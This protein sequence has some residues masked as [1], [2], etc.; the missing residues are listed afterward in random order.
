M[1]P[2]VGNRWRNNGSVLILGESWYGTDSLEERLNGWF[3]RGPDYLLSRVFNAC[4]SSHT[5]A[6]SPT[7]RKAFWNT[8]AFHNFVCWS[9]GP[10]S[11]C[12]PKVA[13]YRRA[14]QHLVSVLR[15]LRPACVWLLGV[16]Q[17]EYSEPVVESQ[18]IVVE[19][20]GILAL[21]SATPSSR[22]LGTDSKSA[23][24][25]FLWLLED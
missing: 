2:W 5:D 20:S 23:C 12:R 16:G 24:A 15:E 19:R 18:K 4:S 25:T 14:A 21:E 6:A 10:H 1:K 11:K 13:D 3:D 17:A 22:H 9:V 8:V 7:D